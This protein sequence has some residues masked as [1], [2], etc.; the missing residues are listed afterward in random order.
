[1]YVQQK[2]KSF[3]LV[4]LVFNFVSIQSFAY[5]NYTFYIINNY[6]GKIYQQ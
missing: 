3:D 4:V 6:N 2:K 1:M 5:L